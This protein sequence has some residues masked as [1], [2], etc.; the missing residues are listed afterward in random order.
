M[1]GINRDTVVEMFDRKIIWLFVGLT[2][3][4]LLVVFLTRG[5]EFNIRIDTAGDAEMNDMMATLANPVTRAIGSYLSFLI[6]LAVLGSA[7]HLPH[8]LE[9][10]R[11]DFYLARPITR[12]RLLTA[13][14]A[15][16]ALAYGTMILLSGAVVYL[17]LVAAHG[18]AGL[19]IL[20]L[21]ASSLTA[22]LIWLSVT[23][24]AAVISGSTAMAIMA[25]FLVW[26]AQTI[27]SYHMMFKGFFNS[28]IAGY[29]IDGLYY[30]V[31]KPSAIENIGLTLAY[32]AEVKDWLPLWTTLPVAFVLLVASVSLFKRHD[33]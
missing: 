13:R 12:T 21:F 32:G 5:V 16:I 1:R 27:L 2:A 26:V 25:A 20:Y 17:A 31:P 29:V 14:L 10:G 28:E 30:I 9:R 33:Y 8:M 19:N 6:F 7:G 4:S 18:S 23:A 11:I 15:G 24:L 3:F 22:F